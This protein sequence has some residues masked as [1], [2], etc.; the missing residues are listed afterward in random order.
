M[1]EDQRELLEGKS[2]ES[3]SQLTNNNSL[4]PELEGAWWRAR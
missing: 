4:L 3:L 1:L 2:D